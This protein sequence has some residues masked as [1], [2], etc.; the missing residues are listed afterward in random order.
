M[1]ERLERLLREHTRGFRLKIH[2]F[3]LGLMLALAAP[4]AAQGCIAGGQ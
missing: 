2:S 1:F 3:A 4:L